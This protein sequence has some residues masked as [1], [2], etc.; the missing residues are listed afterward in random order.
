MLT[1]RTAYQLH[2]AMRIDF[3]A[4]APEADVKAVL[5]SEEGVAAGKA[6]VLGSL[7]ELQ[8]AVQ[9]AAAAESGDESEDMIQA[10]AIGSR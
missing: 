5:L 4:Q 1:G 7:Q 2:C 8:Q 3:T 10:A 9:A 6:K